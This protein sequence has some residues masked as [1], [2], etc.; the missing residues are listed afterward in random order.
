MGLPGG[1]ACSSFDECQDVCCEAAPTP[2]PTS[3][4]TPAPTTPVP[5]T[6]WHHYFSTRKGLGQCPGGMVALPGGTACSSFDECQDVCCEAAPTP[7]PTS[8]PT[9]AP[10]PEWPTPAPTPKPVPPTC[11]HQYFTTRKGLGRCP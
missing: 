2:A 4:P 10:T 9:P 3:W 8:W 11:W 1:T 7:A 6:C 5:P